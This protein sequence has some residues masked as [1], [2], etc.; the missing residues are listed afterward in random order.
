M[1]DAALERIKADDFE[2]ARVLLEEVKK[3]RPNDSFVI[4]QLALAAYKSKKPSPVAAL[5]AARE[6]LRELGPE[7][8]NNPETLGLWGAVHKRLW[9][10]CGRAECLDESIAAYERGFYLKQ[11]HYTGINLAYLLNV[12]ALADLRGGQRDEATADFVLARRVR[13]D[14]V[15][16]AAPLV[17]SLED[18]LSRYWVIAS[19]WEAAVGLGDADG[20][21][22]WEGLASAITVPDWMDATRREQGEKLKQLL[23]QYADGI[24]GV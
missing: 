1:Q 5:E 21:G 23:Q 8:T 7:S 6:I 4:Q 22:R 3:L 15:R 16:Y 20:A 2:S 10:E 14:V 13:K 17:D 18:P 11:D 9:E 24:S 12:R 19:L